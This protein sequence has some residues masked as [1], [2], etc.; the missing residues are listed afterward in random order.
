LIIFYKTIP[1][2]NDNWRLPIILD[3]VEWKIKTDSGI[4]INWVG[5]PLTSDRMMIS[6][7]NESDALA[8]RLK[9]ECDE[10]DT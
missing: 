1:G 8:F 6:F 3:I 4:T 9:Y 10:Q 2:A 7:Q 5:N